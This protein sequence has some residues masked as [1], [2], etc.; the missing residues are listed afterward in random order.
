MGSV[1]N[2]MRSSRLHIIGNKKEKEKVW[3]SEE[4]RGCGNGHY[5]IALDANTALFVEDD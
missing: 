1:R 2:A 5:Y 4:L 3:S